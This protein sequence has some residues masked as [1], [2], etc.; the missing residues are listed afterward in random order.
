MLAAVGGLVVAAAIA[1]V[2][3]DFAKVDSVDDG[4]TDA[5]DADE[6]LTF[7]E[8][9]VPET[10][11][12]S[13]D[14]CA[15]P[16]I[17]CS[18]GCVDPNTDSKN[19]GFCTNRC[20]ANSDCQFGSCRCFFGYSV[21]GTFC[22]DLQTNPSNCGKCATACPTGVTCFAGKCN[23]P[24]SGADA[25]SDTASDTGKVDT[26]TADTGTADTGTADTG[27]ADTGIADTVDEAD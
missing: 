14:V 27:T 8:T 3:P 23:V 9:T 17:S 22:V 1:C 11:D 13:S 15:A 16:R 7:D 18:T 10:G 25:P 12:T 21:C 5:T 20:T 24:D 19:C 4:A 26:G 6:T 2:L